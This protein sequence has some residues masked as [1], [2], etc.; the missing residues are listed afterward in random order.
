[1][2]L[3][4]IRWRYGAD[5]R[6][7]GGRWLFGEFPVGSAVSDGSGNPRRSLRDC[8]RCQGGTPRGEGEASSAIHDRCFQGLTL[9]E[10][11]RSRKALA[12]PQLHPPPPRWQPR[13]LDQRDNLRPDFRAPAQQD[14]T[15]HRSQHLQNAGCSTPTRSLIRPLR[16]NT[17]FPHIIPRRIPRISRSFLA[18]RPADC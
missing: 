9:H 18:F 5:P 11:P 10:S 12:I 14:Q 16:Y 13:R 3:H 1:M 17:H 15:R 6:T 7:G 8:A 2:R 4:R